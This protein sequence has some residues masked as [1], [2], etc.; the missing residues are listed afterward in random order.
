MTKTSVKVNPFCISNYAGV[1]PRH[2]HGVEIIVTKTTKL[3]LSFPEAKKLGA[4]LL[5]AKRQR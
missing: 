1:K 4:S 5:K 3:V 2:T